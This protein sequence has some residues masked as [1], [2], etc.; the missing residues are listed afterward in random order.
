LVR[1]DSRLQR[2]AALSIVIALWVPA[3]GFGIRTLLRYANT[4]GRSAVAPERWPAKTS[5][6]AA[7][8]RSTLL[9]FVH[10]QCGCS[11]AT[12]G[13]LAHIIACC[14]REVDATV[15]F[16]APKSMP[17]EWVQGDLREN[18][19]A[20][21]G[22]RVLDDPDGNTARQFGVHTSGQT[23]LYDAGGRLVFQGGITASRGHSG[24]N[25]G[26]DTITALLAGQTPHR[27][28][29]PVFGCALLDENQGL[30]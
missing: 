5:L 7:I 16:Y 13:E 2:Q 23:L 26:R 30:N 20:I 1:F 21:P 9:L 12:I 27:P 25:A 8:G 4:P 28:A 22:V 3:V 6:V 17:K 18:A 14:S 24:D 10:P 15:L 19:T 29:T 11:R